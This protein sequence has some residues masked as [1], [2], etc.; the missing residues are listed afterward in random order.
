[1]A[2]VDALPMVS[3]SRDLRSARHEWKRTF[4]DPREKWHYGHRYLPGV[5]VNQI[6]SLNETLY[7]NNK[8]MVA[9]NP[10]LHETQKTKSRPEKRRPAY[11]D[12]PKETG[13]R[14]KPRLA[15]GFSARNLTNQIYVQD[16]IDDMERFVDEEVETMDTVEGGFSPED[17]QAAIAASLA[18]AAA[19]TESL[20]KEPTATEDANP[21]PSAVDDSPSSALNDIIEAPTPPPLPLEAFVK[22]TGRETER[23]VEREYEVL[24]DNGEVVKGKRVRRVLRGNKGGTSPKGDDDLEGFE[25]I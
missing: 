22:T 5:H 10:R 25:L 1:M 2:T 3:P 16:E 7:R 11:R 9:H 20:T 15:W 8:Y 23:L 4:K 6:A 21:T 19:N 24:D 18:D 13:N 14:I 12:F 17:I